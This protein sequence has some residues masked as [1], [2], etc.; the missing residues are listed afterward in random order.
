[1]NEMTDNKM[2][3]Y[4]ITTV[5][6]ICMLPILFL[7]FIGLGLGPSSPSGYRISIVYLMI[8]TELTSWILLFFKRPKSAFII[9]L[10]LLLKVIFDFTF[11]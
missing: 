7:Y 9:S 3:L 6:N 2:F 5:I 11:Y 10:L 1:M 4:F 8:I